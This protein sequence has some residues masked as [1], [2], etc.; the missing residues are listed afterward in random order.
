MLIQ[1][2]YIFSEKSLRMNLHIFFTILSYLF[3]CHTILDYFS[4]QIL[5]TLYVQK[6]KNIKKM[7]LEAENRFV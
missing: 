7:D 1:S 5:Q 6:I 2:A 3:V 4:L